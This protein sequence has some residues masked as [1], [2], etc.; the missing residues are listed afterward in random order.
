MVSY[1]Q[2]QD[3]AFFDKIFKVRDRVESWLG[4]ENPPA[5][6][7]C[8]KSGRGTLSSTP[9]AYLQP[10]FTNY[11]LSEVGFQASKFVNEKLKYQEILRIS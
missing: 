9:G 10:Y 8:Q 6:Q 3:H 4:Q 11:Y 7:V 5:L 2:C 1:N